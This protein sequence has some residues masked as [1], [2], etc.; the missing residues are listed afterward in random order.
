[1]EKKKTKKKKKCYSKVKKRV[2]CIILNAL[3]V[4][5]LRGKT[6]IDRE[7][8]PA[9]STLFPGNKFVRT[10]MRLKP[11]VKEGTKI[12]LQKE[13]CQISFTSHWESVRFLRE[14]FCYKSISEI[15]SV[16]SRKFTISLPAHPNSIIRTFCAH[17]AI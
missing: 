9:L 5:N 13:I 7:R 2:H 6:A 4:A 8:R 14:S 16:M 17:T 1:M 3:F 10:K 15:F 11:S 12:E